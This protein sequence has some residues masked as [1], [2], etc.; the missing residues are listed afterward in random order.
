MNK[1]IIKAEL[2]NIK[3]IKST[4]YGNNEIYTFSAEESPILMK[5]VGRLREIT[6]RAAGGGTG[7]EY[8]IDNFDISDNPFKQLIIWCPN[9]EQIIGGYR[10][11][12]GWEIEID[13][14]GCI[15]TPSGE[16]FSFSEEFHKTY[17]PYMIELG[18]SFVIPEYQATGSARKG[19]AALDN[20][21]DGIGS[22]IV[23]NIDRAKYFFGKF[24]MYRNFDTF[25]RDLILR[26]LEYYF[27]NNEHLCHAIKPITREYSNQLLDS[28]FCLNS[29][30][31]DLKTL[32]T[33]LKIQEEIVPPLVNSYI[34]LTKT[35]K[36]FGTTIN[37]TFGDVEESGI[38]LTIG[39]MEQ[40]KY[41]RYVLNKMIH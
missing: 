18:R 29:P 19:L 25:S 28:K 23:E 32:H 35:L 39:D 27:G 24:T 9:S 16:L 3:F 21:W 30:E 15:N 6:F 7:K 10:Y 14:N 12:Y 22:I 17:T 1:E 20:L 40:R 13:D 4:D 37:T 2:K 11:K 36:Y 33:L 38:L 34:N 8:D 31:E 41:E 5:E 26:F